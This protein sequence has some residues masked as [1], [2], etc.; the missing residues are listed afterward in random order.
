MMKHLNLLFLLCFLSN[1]TVWAQSIDPNQ[2]LTDL[3]QTKKWFEIE[4]YYQ[5]HKDSIDSE[6]VTLWYLAE[7]RNAFNRPSEAINAYEQLINK[8]PLNMDT[9][10]LIGLF[11]QPLLQLCADVQEYGKAEEFCH[12]LITLIEN[13]TILDP[14]V[15]LSYI[16]GFT[17]ANESFKMF[18]K[19]YPKLKITKN[20][21]DNIGR[22]ELTPK[23]SSNGIFF[24]TKWN[25]KLLK[26][27]FDTGAGTTY[28][29][30]KAIAEKIGVKLNE[31]DT[32]ITNGGTI[33]GLMGIVDSLELGDFRIKNIP[34]F[35]NIETIDTSDSI[36]VK[37]DSIMNSMYDIVLGIPVIKQLGIIE[38]DFANSTM[39]FPKTTGLAYEKNLYIDKTLYLNMKVCDTNFVSFFDTGG[40]LGLTINNDFYEKNKDCISVEEQTAKSGIFLGGCNQA[41]FSYGNAYDCPL[42]DIKINDLVITMTNDCSVAKDKES[43]NRLGIEEGGFLGNSI[44]KYCKKA[45]FDFVNMVFKMER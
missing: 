38:F 1:I 7:T 16:Q 5:Q 4:D 39:S 42:I 17:Q 32:I 44:F 41:S 13:D 25:G 3:I 23:D 19:T 11:G 6:F 33:R 15:R 40:E 34:V 26:T 14:D 45:T 20:D 10:T 28:I 36:Q 9:P 37:C 22:I 24:N 27:F 2:T 30:N 12:K 18:S 35:V 8:N 31:S 21:D 29:Y 43:N